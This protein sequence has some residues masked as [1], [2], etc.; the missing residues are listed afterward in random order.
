MKHET[1][2]YKVFKYVNLLILALIVFVTV[3]PFLNVIAQS[4]SSK[5]AID[6]GQVS[7]LPKGF[8]TD[9][10]KYLMSD[11]MFWINY[12]NTLIYTV[13]GTAVSIFLTTTLAYALSKKHVPGIKIFV[14]LA[15]FTM[16]FAGG[17]IPNYLLIRQLGWLNTIWAIIIPSALSIY[18]MIIMKSFFE[19]IPEALEEAATIDGANTYKIFWSIILPLSKPIIAT[20][21]LFYAVSGWNAWFDAFLYIDKKELFPVTVY[22]RN[23][24]K[25]QA[26]QTAGAA[27]DAPTISANIKAVTMFLTVLP[28]LCV[29]PFVQKHFVTGIM[30]GSVK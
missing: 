1:T 27:S 5:A 18:N 19:G 25:G 24:I 6:A 7:I 23:I 4:F 17:L 10:Y 29:Y 13:V 14:G 11:K 2:A 21:L 20:M 16:Y 3:F 30:L 28:I 8:N 15:V 12:K 9:T 22:L 26:D